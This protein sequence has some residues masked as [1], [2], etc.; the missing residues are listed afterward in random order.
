MNVN[1]GETA[2]ATKKLKAHPP[3]DDDAAIWIFA[4]RP[5]IFCHSCCLLCKKKYMSVVVYLSLKI[6]NDVTN[7][8]KESKQIERH[9][10]S[11]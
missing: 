9:I 6:K 11:I 5:V 1:V 7:L 3:R 2:T 8:R 10:T 4:S